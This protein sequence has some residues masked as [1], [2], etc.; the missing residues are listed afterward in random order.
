[1]FKEK[2]DYGWIYSEMAKMREWIAFIKV[3]EKELFV[4]VADAK[5]A[6]N[7]PQ[8]R[9]T[10][11]DYAQQSQMKSGQ[12]L[13]KLIVVKEHLG[14]FKKLVFAPFRYKSGS[15]RKKKQW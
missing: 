11:G 4:L 9:W 5:N 7:S 12:I 3:E 8:A 14:A 15:N 10:L 2:P 1:M 13:V 6:A